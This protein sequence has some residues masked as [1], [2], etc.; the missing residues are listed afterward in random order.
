MWVTTQDLPRTA[1]HPFYTRMNQIL[2]KHDFD[3][4][5]EGLCVRHIIGVCGCFS[6]WPIVSQAP[7][8]RPRRSAL[9][10]WFH[11]GLLVGHDPDGHVHTQRIALPRI[12]FEVILVVAFPLPAV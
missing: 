3:G 6:R 4:D 1:A 11:H 2:D 8:A 9:R 12:G 5:V 7:D 10:K